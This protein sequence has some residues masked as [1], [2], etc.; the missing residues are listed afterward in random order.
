MAGHADSRTSKLYDRRAQKILLEDMKRIRYW[1]C[2]STEGSNLFLTVLGVSPP[3]ERS[4][5]NASRIVCFANLVADPS[6]IFSLY[7]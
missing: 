2:F 1:I 6:M 7:G 3:F 5:K 4:I